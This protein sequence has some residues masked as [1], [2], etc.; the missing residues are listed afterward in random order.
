MGPRLY[1]NWRPERGWGVGSLSTAATVTV[2]FAVLAPVLAVSIAPRI[3]LPLAAV[4]VVVVVAVVVRVGGVTAAEVLTR[5]VRFTRAR[6][7]GWTQLSAGVLTD[8]PRGHDL[9]GLFAPVVPLDVDD[10]RGGRYALLWDRRTGTLSAVLRCSP[11]G[12]DLADPGQVDTWIAGWGALLADLGYQPLVAH[13]AVTVD[14]AP[15]G[16]TT[17]RDHLAA[18]VDPHAPGAGPHRARRA[19]RATPATAAEVDARLTVTFDPRRAHPRPPDLLAA[20]V[21]AGRWLPGIETAL[22]GCGVAV[23]GRASTGVVDRA[24]PG[25]VRPGHPPPPH[26]PHRQ[27]RRAG[28]AAGVGRGRAGRRGR[29]LG[30]LPAR[31]RGVGVLGAARGPPPGRGRPGPGPALDSRPVPPPADLAV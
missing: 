30:A 2:F 17:V 14:T 13:V 27:R 28:G 26:P 24:D 5:R 12:L 8:H 3:A 7:A 1:G 6:A 11:I 10:G 22:A 19:R 16:G 15:T 4:G 29:V 9:P 25:R 23:L 21:D 31:L 18:A 20:V